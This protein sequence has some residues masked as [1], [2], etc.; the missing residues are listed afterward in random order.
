MI[1]IDHNQFHKLM[2]PMPQEYNAVEFMQ[3]LEDRYGIKEMKP[4]EPDRIRTDWDVHFVSPYAEMFFRI[5]Y[6]EM[7]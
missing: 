1:T 2:L 7:L 4:I 3:A 6:A 5:T